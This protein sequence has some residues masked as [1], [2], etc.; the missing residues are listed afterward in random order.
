M[1]RRLLCA[2]MTVASVFAQTKQ[3]PPTAVQVSGRALLRD[4]KALGGSSFTSWYPLYAP[5]TERVAFWE[6][7]LT[8]A[9]GWESGYAIFRADGRLAEF[10][11]RGSSPTQQLLRMDIGT[12][13]RIS[14]FGPHYMAALSGRGA[15]SPALATSRS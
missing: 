3:T 13:V 8:S 1:N 15:G 7:R 11:T 14:R 9:L 6:G 5:L 2:I 10:N 4:V 12:T